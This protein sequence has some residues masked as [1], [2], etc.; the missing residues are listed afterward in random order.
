MGILD[1][2]R[3]L[4]GGEAEITTSMAKVKARH[5]TGTFPSLT[6]RKTNEEVIR[7]TITWAR[8]IAGDNRFHYGYT[9]K[10]GSKNSKKWN[11]NAHHN[12]CYFCG[13]NTTKGGRSKKGIV[14]YKFTY[15]CNPF[16]GA[17][18]AHGGCVQK[19]LEL[20]QK[21]TSW[22][23]HKG[24]GYDA[25][26]LFKKLGKPAKSK[27][28]AGDVLCSDSHVALYV[29]NGKVIHASGGDDN[30]RNSKKWNNSIRESTWNGW[31]RAYRFT[32]SVNFS[33]PIRHGEVG[34]RVRHLQLFLSWYG[35][36]LVADGVFGDKTLE[37]VKRFQKEQKITADGIVGK[38]T[39][40]KMHEVV[41]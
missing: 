41:K 18:W 28:K 21:G 13:T 20:C 27:L 22:D 14:D 34:S 24:K 16:V 32:G 23:Y 39:L 2:I 3:N 38:I 30:V 11:P 29:G 4:I 17:A 8:W 26:K 36:S 7:D 25:S 1:K 9:N 37:A 15:C 33:A 31:K 6:I 35:I 19:A 40:Q 12:G 10:H 5:Y